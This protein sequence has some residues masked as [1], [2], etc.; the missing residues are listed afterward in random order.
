MEVSQ[1]L[2]E[3]LESFD[4]YRYEVQRVQD[5]KVTRLRLFQTKQD[6]L[7]AVGLRE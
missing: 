3:L 5:G 2:K 1:R 4:D 7:E 6:A